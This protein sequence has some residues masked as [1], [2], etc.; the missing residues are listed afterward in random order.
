MG[1]AGPGRFHPKR[2]HPISGWPLFEP[3]ASSQSELRDVRWSSS[4]GPTATTPQRRFCARD[5]T[6]HGE[7]RA[8]TAVSAKQQTERDEL[9]GPLLERGLLQRSETQPVL[10]QIG[11]SSRWMLDSLAVTLT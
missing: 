5:R 2:S 10:S 4:R 11:R 1:A 6:G 9:L 8:S 3:R 7:M